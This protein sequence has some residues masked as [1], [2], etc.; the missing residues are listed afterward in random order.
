MDGSNDARYASHAEDDGRLRP[1]PSLDAEGLVGRPCPPS[2]TTPTT[3]PANT[4]P[5]H[6]KSVK[7]VRPGEGRKYHS[8][9]SGSQSSSGVVR[10]DG[11]Q[12]RHPSGHRR[13]HDRP[14][15][16]ASATNRPAIAAMAMAGPMMFRMSTFSRLAAL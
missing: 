11:R 5:A 15:A 13:E 8:T 16:P 3:A 10:H 7:F 12:H 14:R 2:M 6:G 4:N 1:G 9:G